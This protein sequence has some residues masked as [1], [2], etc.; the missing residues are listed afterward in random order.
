MPQRTPQ[1]FINHLQ[2]LL[3][4]KEEGHAR[5][6]ARDTSIRLLYK[7]ANGSA[8]QTLYKTLQLTPWEPE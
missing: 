4:R 1:N 5:G 8:M 3:I 7:K 2:T 6:R